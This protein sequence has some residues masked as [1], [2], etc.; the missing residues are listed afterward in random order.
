[1]IQNHRGEYCGVSEDHRKAAQQNH[2]DK[3]DARAERVSPAFAGE[4]V[5]DAARQQR[6]QA[7][8]DEVADAAA[9]RSKMIEA[10]RRRL[11]S[12]A[13]AQAEQQSLEIVP[14]Q[15]EE[16]IDIAAGDISDM[17]RAPYKAK[18]APSKYPLVRRSP[19][20]PEAK[21]SPPESPAQTGSDDLDSIF[22][23]ESNPPR[24]RLARG[25]VT[26]QLS[27]GGNPDIWDEAFQSAQRVE[28][29]L[30]KLREALAR[31]E[32]H[33]RRA[34]R[35]AKARSGRT[36]GFLRV[37][38]LFIASFL[39]GSSALIF[40]YDSRSR[41]SVE[42][43]LAQFIDELWPQ[44]PAT[45]VVNPLPLTSVKSAE[46]PL[47]VAVT[48]GQ[49]KKIAT[50][51]LEAF[52]A[53]G[54][55]DAGIPLSFHVLG[56]SPDQRIDIHV[57]GVP[58]DAKLSAGRRQKDGSWLLKPNEQSG[59]K[60]NVAPQSSGSLKLTI[61]AWEHETGELAAPPQEIEVT[62][63]SRKVAAK[64]KAA[65]AVAVANIRQDKAIIP[66][67]DPAPVEP[68]AEPPAEEVELAAIEE[69]AEAP[70]M[71]VGIDDPSLPLLARGDTLMELGDVAAA[72]SFYD[73]AFELGNVRAAR[74]IA[75]TY[76]PIVLAS[77][78]V[79][80]LRADPAK[81]LEW[82]HKAE[83]AGESD[84]TQDIAALESFLGQ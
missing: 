67:K 69:A 5:R 62:I 22:A 17:K 70:A 61:E 71:A 37:A 32:N 60:L 57:W 51:K 54:R 10:M 3:T 28:N 16:K 81:A 45:V 64:P 11:E 73:R 72:R 47:A 53:Q 1:V 21:V 80:G 43:Q 65:P 35:A 12:E 9:L 27:I 40:V 33:G 84:V 8:H 78:N 34:R 20:G 76:D 68:A 31:N 42:D 6:I 23:P 15:G 4:F 44:K 46:K 7:V 48:D 55:A 75:R 59:L 36:P 83:K 39:I 2:H 14:P 56:A 50:L 18:L 77:M 38:T 24:H 25:N 26:P 63:A 58:Q 19:D 41:I 74:S 30:A 52:D 79:Q 66:A 49:S 13:A 29:A 82:Y